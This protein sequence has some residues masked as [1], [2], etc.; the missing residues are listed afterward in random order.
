MRIIR[1]QPLKYTGTEMNTKGENDGIGSDGKLKKMA[2]LFRGRK[3]KRG[4][5]G[6]LSPDVR[7]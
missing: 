2:V 7:N 3:R 6:A 1:F 5:H 4:Q